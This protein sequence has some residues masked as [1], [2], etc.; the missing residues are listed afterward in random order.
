MRFKHHFIQK[1]DNRLNNLKLAWEGNLIKLSQSLDKPHNKPTSIIINLTPNCVLRCRQC[2]IWKNAPAQHLNLNDAKTILDKL[3]GWLG[4]TY[5]FFAGGEPLMNKQLPQ[6]IG[7]AYKIGIL[8]HVNSNAVLINQSV[9]QKLCDNRMF[10]ISISLDGANHSTHDYL[11]GQAGTFDK[12]IKAIKLL[13]NQEDGSPSI[14]LN[15]V[16]MK[17]NVDE[18]SALVQLAKDLR[19]QGITFQCLLPN[20]GSADTE[21][22]PDK[23]PL[24]PKTKDITDAL[25]R[26]IKIA[27]SEP[28]VLTRPAQLKTAINYYKD[29][30]FLDSITCA[31]GINNF[32]IDHQGDVRLC[33][34]FPP[35]GNILTDSPANIWWSKEAQ[36]QR[37]QIRSCRQSCKV[38]LCNQSDLR[39]TQTALSIFSE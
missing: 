31:A 36:R 26:I 24:W 12:V 23:N 18:L 2:D 21:I 17:D 29:P 22:S 39:R 32:I 19:T 35:I 37:S 5:V 10:A 30:H 34:G 7:Y 25:R 8:S 11:R 3:R 1:I 20:L 9:A 4:P 16:M 33:F 27:R 13:Q 6:M 14:Y 38:I 15:T 28:L